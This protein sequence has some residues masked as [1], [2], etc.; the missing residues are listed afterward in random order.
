MG[1]VSLISSIRDLSPWKKVLDFESNA[2]VLACFAADSLGRIVLFEDTLIRLTKLPARTLSRMPV[3]NLKEHLGQK[4]LGLRLESEQSDDLFMRTDYQGFDGQGILIW[5]GFP[6]GTLP[7]PAGI[8]FL[9]FIDHTAFGNID[10][11]VSAHIDSV[12]YPLIIQK[13][14]KIKAAVARHLLDEYDQRALSEGIAQLME[15]ESPALR[16]HRV[17]LV[18]GITLDDGPKPLYFQYEGPPEK[19]KMIH[20]SLMVGDQNLFRKISQSRAHPTL[21]DHTEKPW[22]YEIFLPLTWHVHI[23]GWIGIPLPSIDIWMDPVRLNFEEIVRSMGDALGE[24]RMSLGLLPAYDV[25]RGLFGE[26]SFMTLMEDLI[27][28]HPP[29][30]FVLLL[31]RGDAGSR[32]AIQ[33]V[34]DRAKCSCDILAQVNEGL[35]LLFPDQDISKAKSIEERYR[36]LLEKRVA[37]DPDLDLTLSVY[38]F[39]STVWTGRDLMNNL[40]ARPQIEISHAS[41]AAYPQKSFDEWFKRFLILKDWT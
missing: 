29:R 14:D 12:E 37:T 28:C 8:Y 36:G 4:G 2:N 35:V 33:G 26:E 38:W 25:H 1:F 13:R 6:L 41:G 10:H 40:L 11:T 27:L 20:D 18:E 34:L 31:I 17:F 23:M 39:P 19:M 22:K 16:K 9:R 30:S 15:W 21:V 3:K 32:M 24:V 7:Q 5:W